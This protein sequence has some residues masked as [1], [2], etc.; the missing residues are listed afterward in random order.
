MMGRVRAIE[1]R[2]WLVRSVNKGVAGTVN[3]LGQPVRTLAS[4]EQTQA[5][6]VRPKLLTGR[7]VFNRVGDWPALLLALGMIGYAVRVDRREG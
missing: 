1:N 2:R 5:L 4:G 6:S 3:D 7:T